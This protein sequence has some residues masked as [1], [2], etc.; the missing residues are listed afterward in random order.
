[1][2]KQ[3]L[4]STFFAVPPECIQRSALSVI[5]SN[6]SVLRAVL[7]RCCH[8]LSWPHKVR[9]SSIPT[10]IFKEKPRKIVAKSGFNLGEQDTLESEVISRTS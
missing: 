10:D 8:A 4:T 7:R 3:L 2:N 9:S 1:M 6:D 5:G